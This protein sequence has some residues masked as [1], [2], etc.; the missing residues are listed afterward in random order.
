MLDR[1]IRS[2]AAIS[3]LWDCRTDFER[4]EFLMLATPQPDSA[5]RLIEIVT[6]AHTD[7]PPKGGTIVSRRLLRTLLARAIADHDALLATHSEIQR[8]GL[9]SGLVAVLR[10]ALTEVSDDDVAAALPVL[11]TQPLSTTT[12][13]PDRTASTAQEAAMSL[14]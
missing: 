8:T 13:L 3:Y 11:T 9:P 6:R 1:E 4:G 14:R 2:V 5:D 7:P 12:V 10:D